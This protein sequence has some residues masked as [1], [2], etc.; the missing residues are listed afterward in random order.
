MD[1]KLV[2]SKKPKLKGEDGHKV[3]SVRLRDDIVERLEKI[4]ITTN[5]TR[6]DLINTMLD[7]A[8]DNSEVE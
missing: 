8:L 5:R 7:F 2:I 3:F 6:N 4:V 1:K